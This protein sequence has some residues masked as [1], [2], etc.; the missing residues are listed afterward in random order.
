MAIVLFG[1]TATLVQWLGL[2]IA[3]A[4]ICTYSFIKNKKKELI[5]VDSVAFLGYDE[6]VFE[7]EEEDD[8]AV[9][10][11]WQEWGAGMSSWVGD[12]LD[13][14]PDEILEEAQNKAQAQAFGAPA[15]TTVGRID[16][17]LPKEILPAAEFEI[18]DVHS[19]GAG[20]SDTEDPCTDFSTDQEMQ[21]QVAPPVFSG[22]L[23]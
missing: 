11:E 5:S 1:E 19:N 13:L 17:Q 18:G 23:Q 8:T 6:L 12:I 9:P 22:Q 21:M 20:N 15:S 7:E 4:G 16:S 3:L 2:A 14:G 10:G